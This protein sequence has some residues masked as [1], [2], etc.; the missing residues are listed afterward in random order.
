MG[1]LRVA[2]TLEMFKSCSIDGTMD[3]KIPFP[4]VSFPSVE[5]SILWNCSS[6]SSHSLTTLADGLR[7][8]PLS[9]F[10]ASP[11]P[12]QVSSKTSKIPFAFCLMQLPCPPLTLVIIR[13]R[14][15]AD[16]NCWDVGL[17]LNPPTARTAPKNSSRW[18]WL[19]LYARRYFIKESC[20]ST[21]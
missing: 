17:L 13:R 7:N 11:T 18:P 16:L 1:L 5:V 9:Y 10:R 19:N 2:K 15:Y 8:P 14:L 3:C 12:L 21:S 20:F 4:C 6:V